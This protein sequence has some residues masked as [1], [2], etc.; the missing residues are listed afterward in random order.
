MIARN[1]DNPYADAVS[2]MSGDYVRVAAGNDGTF[3]LNGL[4]PGAR[5]ALYTDMIVVGGFPT[6]QPLYLPEGEEFYNGAN[7]SGNGLIDD[8]CQMAPITATAGSTTTADIVLNTVAGAPKFSTMLPNAYAR[9]VSTDGSV[10]GGSVSPG[11]TF[12]WSEQDGLQILNDT[13][14]AESGMSRDGLSFASDTLGA[15]GKRVASVLH[16]GSSWQQ[17]PLPVAEAPAVNMPTGCGFTSTSS[18]ISADGNT[19]AGLS[20]VDTNGSLPGQTCKYRP[21]IWTA[22]GGSI[23]LQAPLN[24]RNVRVNGMSNDRSTIVGFHD[25]LGPRL[26]VRWVNGVFEELSTPSLSVGEAMYVTPDGSTFTGGNAGPQLKPW[27]WTRE[28][29]LQLLDR[30]APNFSA[31]ALSAS[32]D[33]K[34]VGGLGGSFSQSAGDASGNRAFLWT[35]DLGTVDFENFLQAQGTFFEGWVL[36]STSSMS[37]DGTIQVGSGAG[38][39]GAAGWMINM[40]KVNICHAAPGRPRNTHTINVPF[41]GAMADHL[42]HGDTIGV[43]TDSE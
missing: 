24:F 18:R 13:R 12:R 26:G 35:P 15:D 16:L 41:V 9:N 33:G 2:A 27:I 20:F 34:V 29:G 23:F 42:R 3:T 39:R 7:E 21:F 31:F 10:I 40:E 43:C 32:D 30:T 19:V 5:Y 36:W 11:G 37:A 38:P 22:G 1:L 25:T 17:L 8:R 4:T 28:G 14:D 6:V